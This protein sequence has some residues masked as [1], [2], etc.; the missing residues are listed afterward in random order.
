MTQV[1]GHRGAKGEA[2]ENTL[3]GFVHCLEQGIRRCELDLHL[4]SD[5]ELMVIHD[6]TLMRTTGK[7]GDVI[8]FAAKELVRMDA[9]QAGPAWPVPCPIPRL[10]ELFAKCRFEHWQLEVKNVSKGVAEK[11]AKEIARLADQYSVSEVITVTSASTLVLDALREFAPHLKRGLVAERSLRCPVDKALRYGCSLLALNWKAC[12][13]ERVAKAKGAGVHLS[14]WTVNDA[15]DM[16]RL[17]KLGVD[18]IIT[19]FPTLAL[20]TIDEW[21]T[22]ESH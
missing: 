4:S 8:E 11:M 18:S 14:V 2:P 1:Y 13:A 20:S 21:A 19:D 6:P 12:T 22:A 5:G 9:R 17:A 3:A 7:L 10:C 16:Q 15:S